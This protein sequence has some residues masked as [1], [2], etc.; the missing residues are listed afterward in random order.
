MLSSNLAETTFQERQEE[1]KMKVSSSNCFQCGDLENNHLSSNFEKKDDSVAAD[2]NFHSSPTRHRITASSI[3]LVRAYS[4][5]HIYFS[6][7]LSDEHAVK[8]TL[9]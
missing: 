8:L 1:L 3:Q 4:N 5:R 6:Q 9:V 2:N 7:H